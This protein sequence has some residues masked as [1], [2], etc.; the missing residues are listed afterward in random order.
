[1]T[2]ETRRPSRRFREIY[3]TSARR[4]S[5]SEPSTDGDASAARLFM[6]SALSV[7]CYFLSLKSPTIGAR[8]GLRASIWVKSTAMKAAAPAGGAGRAGVGRAL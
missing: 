2:V 8:I 4:A 3:G 7:D 1:M 6:V 5:W